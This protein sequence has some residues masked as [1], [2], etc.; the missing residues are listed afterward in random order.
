MPKARYVVT[1]ASKQNAK[2]ESWLREN[3]RKGVVKGEKY[4]RDWVLDGKEVERL[5]RLYP[6]EGVAGG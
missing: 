4:G 1:E 3:L 5:A 2:S 6:R